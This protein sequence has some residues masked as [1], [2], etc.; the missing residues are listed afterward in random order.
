MHK[1]LDNFLLVIERGWRLQ[2]GLQPV[3]VVQREEVDVLAPNNTIT[4]E[5]RYFLEM[6]KFQGEFVVALKGG[7][8][9]GNRA[10]N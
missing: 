4:E 3:V 5:T 1:L 10:V 8:F 7:F 6:G 9:L 2:G